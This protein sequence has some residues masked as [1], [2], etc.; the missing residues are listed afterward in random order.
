MPEAC[1]TPSTSWRPQGRGTG[2]ITLDAATSAPTR[3]ALCGVLQLPIAIF[4]QVPA[5]HWRQLCNR[6]KVQVVSVSEHAQLR[7]RRAVTAA[8]DADGLRG[9]QQLAVS[10]RVAGCHNATQPAWPTERRLLAVWP[11]KHYVNCLPGRQ[12]SEHLQLHS[13]V[14][15]DVDQELWVVVVGVQHGQW[16]LQALLPWP[17]NLHGAALH[18]LVQRRDLRNQTRLSH[19]GFRPGRSYFGVLPATTQA[20]IKH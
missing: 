16:R 12:G 13:A 3:A 18:R 6:R 7:R 20:C 1:N 19:I 4:L 9:R 8:Y 11:S 15:R 10:C 5:L 2:S 14:E 17:Q